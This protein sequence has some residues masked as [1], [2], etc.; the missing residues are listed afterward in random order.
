MVHPYND[1][2]IVQS[3]A[4]AAKEVFQDMNDLDYLVFPIG[5]GGLSSGSCLSTEFF[6]GKCKPIGVEPYLARDAK[7][8]LIKGSLQP[9]MPPVTIADGLRTSLGQITFGILSHYLKPEDVILVEEEE[10]ISAMRLVFERMK[11]VIEPS[12][13]TVVAAVLKDP[14]FKDKK[15]CCIISG[16]NVDMSVFFDLLNSKVKS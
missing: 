15:V 9:Q 2:A 11:I 4:T 6:G 12:C 8:S 5:G 7:Q 10:I 14:R 1:V 16:G 13:A 3:Q